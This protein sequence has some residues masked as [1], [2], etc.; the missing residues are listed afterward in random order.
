MQRLQRFLRDLADET[1]HATAKT[2]RSVLSGIL[3]HAVK[4]GALTTNPVR[5]VGALRKRRD[6]N[7]S[8]DTPGPPRTR[9]ARQRQPCWTLPGCRLVMWPTN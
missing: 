9:C 7:G 6:S 3:G 4:H 1:G 8:A 2:A 5:N